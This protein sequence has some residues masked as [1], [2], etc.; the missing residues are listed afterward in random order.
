LTLIDANSRNLDKRH[1]IKDDSNETTLS[2][3]I[4]SEQKILAVSEEKNLGGLKSSRKASNSRVK[5]QSLSNE[6]V[7]T[8]GTVTNL[9][10]IKSKPRKLGK[11]EK[12]D[13]KKK[14]KFSEITATANLPLLS[15]ILDQSIDEISIIAFFLSD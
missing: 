8:N 6:V 12:N 14:E 5:S 13:L 9:G 3:L 10:K 7:D 15:S 4:I 1:R 11:D 2:E